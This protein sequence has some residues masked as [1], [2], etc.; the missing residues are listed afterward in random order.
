MA[1]MQYDEEF[2]IKLIVGQICVSCGIDFCSLLA[3]LKCS[4]NICPSETAE[5]TKFK[6]TSFSI[7]AVVFV[8][9]VCNFFTAFRYIN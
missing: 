1:L 6:G 3:A 4:K 9:T 2:R 5:K 8:F 7:G